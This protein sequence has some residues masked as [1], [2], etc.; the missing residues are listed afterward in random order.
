[1]GAAER[2]PEPDVL[3]PA[4]ASVGEGPVIDHRTGRLC[5]VDIVEGMLY[6]NDLTDGRQTAASVGDHG[7]RGRAARTCRRV[8]RCGRRRLRLLDIRATRHHG[9]G[10]TRGTPPDERRQMRLT[11]APVGRQHPHAVRPGRRRASPLGRRPIERDDGRWTHPPERPG[12]E[13]RGHHHVPDRQHDQRPPQRLVPSGRGRDRKVLHLVQDRPRAARRLGRRPR[14]LDLGGRLGRRARCAASTARASS[15]GSFQCPSASRPAV[16]S[17]PT[18]PC[19]S[20]P[21][22]TA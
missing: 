4:E 5:W 18:E 19:T 7:R 16:R 15:P 22:G 9:S 13:S 1:M 14:R 11:R 20:P 12:M 6:E 8:R 17:V 21:H 2:F 10:A 3:I